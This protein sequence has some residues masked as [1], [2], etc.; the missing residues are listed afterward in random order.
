MK[1][2]GKLETEVGEGT[3][4]LGHFV[5]IIALADGVAGVVGSILD[6]VG[7]SD[8]HWGA[9][10]GTSEVDE[11]TH[12]ERFGAAGV[13]FQRNLVGRSTDTAGLHLDAGLGV[14]DGAV[15]DLERV[16]GISAFIGAVNSGV[17]DTLGEGALAV[18]HHLGDQAT[19]NL[20]VE[21]RILVNF[22]WVDSF[23]ACHG[24]GWSEIKLGKLLLSARF[25]L[26][27]TVFG[28]ALLTTID[29]EGIE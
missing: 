18:F 6:L 20:A 3:V 22:G 29:P 15:D 12:A 8:V 27:G 19:D 5:N 1:Q 13:Y 7:E 10:F 23:S 4:C 26:L 17:D 14:F 24:I 11:P 9:L 2:K 16:D 28:T 25:G 21:L